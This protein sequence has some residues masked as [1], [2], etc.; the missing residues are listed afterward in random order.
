M[1]ERITRGPAID[2]GEEDF[3]EGI[4]P[5]AVAPANGGVEARRR[6]AFGFRQAGD[7]GGEHIRVLDARAAN[8]GSG[9]GRAICGEAE[10]TASD[11]GARAPNRLKK[12]PA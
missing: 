4:C 9:H 1:I 5:E 3:E 10:L 8:D 2:L 12:R 6:A 11:D 7:E